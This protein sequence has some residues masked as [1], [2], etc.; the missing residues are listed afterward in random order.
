[1]A[2]DSGT[3]QRASRD[4]RDRSWFPAVAALAILLVLGVLIARVV[5]HGVVTDWKLL[6]TC[7]APAGAVPAAVSDAVDASPCSGPVT[8][9]DDGR[10]WPVVAAVLPPSAGSSPEVTRVR[11]DDRARTITLDYRPSATAASQS[12][13]VYVEVPPSTVPGSPVSVLSSATG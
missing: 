12:V 3:T 13:V 2:V 8:T 1:M 4:L 6:A 9:V 10:G 5:R 7:A 11:S